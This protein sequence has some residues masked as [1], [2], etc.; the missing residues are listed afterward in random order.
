MN[1]LTENVISTSVRRMG[2]KQINFEQIPARFPEGTMSRVD[3]VLEP[4]EKRSDFIRGAV[5]RELARR[6]RASADASADSKPAPAERARASKPKKV[7]R[8]A[9]PKPQRRP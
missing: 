8:P 1:A 3:A 4:K 2:R 6:E 5:E 7:T 9:A